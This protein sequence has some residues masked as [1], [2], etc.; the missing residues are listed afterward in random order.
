MRE[1]S[2]FF[3]QKNVPIGR[4]KKQLS[5]FKQDKTLREWEGIEPNRENNMRT[6]F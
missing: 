1:I 4:R 3:P 6:R 5:L 2:F